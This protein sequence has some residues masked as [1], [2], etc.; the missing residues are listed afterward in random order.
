MNT[1]GGVSGD[2]VVRTPPPSAA[3]AGGPGGSV[4][5]GPPANTG[6]VGLIPVSAR[7]LEK[8]MAAHSSILAWTIPRTA[9]PGGL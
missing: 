9:E 1:V 7:S 3:G 4:V 6:D 8:E 5:R 2:A